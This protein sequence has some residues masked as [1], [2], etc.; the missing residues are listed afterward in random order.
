MLAFP[1]EEWLAKQP[2]KWAARIQETRQHI[3]HMEMAFAEAAD[4]VQELSTSF[5]KADYLRV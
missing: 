3:G 5:L 4:Q 1:S 2:E